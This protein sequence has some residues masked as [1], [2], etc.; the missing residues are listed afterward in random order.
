MAFTAKVL[1]IFGQQL[2]KCSFSSILSA[3][4]VLA[5][6]GHMTKMA[7]TAIYG[8]NPP[9]LLFI[10]NQWADCNE[11]WYVT[12]KMQTH[13]SLFKFRLCI[14]LDLFYARVKFGHLCFCMGKR[15]I[16]YFMKIIAAH[17]LKVD[18]CIELNDLMK[19]HEY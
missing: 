6:L 7:A 5:D 14:D 13:H 18:R 19:L 11:I 4:Y 9:K 3:I 8:K 17:D 2:Q 15:K 12:S 1:Q 16:I 10:Q